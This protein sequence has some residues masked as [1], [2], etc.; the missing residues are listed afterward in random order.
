MAE[1]ARPK[2]GGASRDRSRAIGD[3]RCAVVSPPLDD[4]GNTVHV[5]KSDC[6]HLVRA[7][8][9]SV[10]DQVRAMTATIDT[11]RREILRL[12]R[13]IDYYCGVIARTMSRDR[14]L[15]A[16]AVIRQRERQL[17]DTHLDATSHGGRDE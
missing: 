2:R 12:K 7:Q 8:R 13:E 15:R 4:A 9:Q 10:L 6:R 16:H 5:Q 11:R 1:L 14:I 17:R 3:G